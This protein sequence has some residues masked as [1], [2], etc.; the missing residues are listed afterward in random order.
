MADRKVPG[1]EGGEVDPDKDP[2]AGTVDDP[3][4][5]HRK[6]YSADPP[7]TPPD[8]RKEPRTIVPYPEGPGKS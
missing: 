4:E 2:L 3:G 6:G 5:A 8:Q 7:S 1:Q